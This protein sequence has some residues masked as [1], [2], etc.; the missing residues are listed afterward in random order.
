M[1]ILYLVLTL[2]PLLFIAIGCS[3]TYR[4]TDFKSKNEFH[5]DV[6]KHIDN[7]EVYM[8]LN[9]DSTVDKNK[10]ERMTGSS[11]I[12]F[13]ANHNIFYGEILGNGGL[14]SFNYERETSFN[15]SFRVGLG[16]S[17]N[18]ST[19]FGL[20]LGM[21]NYSINISDNNKIEAGGGVLT[22]G[23][24]FIPTFSI[25]YRYSP[26]NGGFFLSFSID[27][28]PARKFFNPW[29]GIGIGVKF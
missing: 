10:T 21:L 12:S 2:P 23:T 15:F 29:G 19:D 27:T 13:P 25:G 8:I 11:N 18:N 26:V 7:R 17:I 24:D 14:F 3:S 6:S 28:V 1:K 16:L 9:N 20:F 4:I 22:L 5:K